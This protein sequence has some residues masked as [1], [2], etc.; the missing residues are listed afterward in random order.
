MAKYRQNDLASILAEVKFGLCKGAKV[1]CVCP[2][3]ENLCHALIE[4]DM[5]HS[6]ALL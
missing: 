3:L 2:V 6:V 4:R 1:V 5:D